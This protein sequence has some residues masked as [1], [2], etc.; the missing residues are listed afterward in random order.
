MR[1]FLRVLLFGIA[2][3]SVGLLAMAVLIGFYTLL[4]T[5]SPRDFV[6]GPEL[7]S[8]PILIATYSVGGIPALLTGIGAILIARRQS[9]WRG[10]LMTAVLGGI[11]TLCEALLLLG[12]RMLI[13]VGEEP[14]IVIVV[15]LAGAIA[16][17]A[18]AMLFDGMA[19]V[20]GGRMAA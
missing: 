15:A 16:G 4:T 12:G 3:P 1:G 2:G 7:T 10:W 8:P 20:R 9:G 6:L 11:I 5:G 17:L 13:G 14:Q 18:C 19:A